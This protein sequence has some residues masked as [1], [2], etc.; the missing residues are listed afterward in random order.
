MHRSSGLFLGGLVLTAAAS[1]AGAQVSS[2]NEASSGAQSAEKSGEPIQDIVVTARRTEENLQRIPVAVTALGANAIR[3]LQIGDVMGLQRAAPSLLVATGS[4][5]GAGFAYVSIRGHFL[6]NPSVENDPSVG[7]YVD[8]V[9]IPRPSQGTVDLV[10]VERAEVLRG[11]QGTLFGRNTPGGALSIVTAQPTEQFEASV[12]GEYGNYDHKNVRAIV[13]GPV[14]AGLSARIVYNFSEHDSYGRN[15][16]TGEGVASRRSHF[17]RGKLRWAPDGSDWDV[18]LSADYNHI[19]GSSQLQTLSGFNPAIYGPAL[20]PFISDRSNFY[21]T[22]F[23]NVSFASQPKPN[24]KIV[25]WGG[26]ATINGQIGDLKVKSITGYR[27]SKPQGSAD[28]DATP[29]AILE[30]NQYYPSRQISQELQVFGDVGDRLKYI[31]GGYYSR[32]TA[33]ALAVARAFGFAFPSLPFA[34]DADVL[35]KSAGLFGQAYYQLTDQLRLTG[36]LRWT[37]DKRSVNLHNVTT[38]GDPSTCNLDSTLP[39]FVAPCSLPQTAKFNYPAWTT[40][41]DFQATPDMLIYAKGSAASQAGGLNTRVGALPSYAPAKT[42][43]VEA[44][45]KTSWFD[46]RLRVNVALFYEWQK[47]V[48]LNKTA[49]VPVI[50]GVTPYLTNAGNARVYGAEFEANAAPW[51]GM[52]LTGTLSLLR[53]HFV[54]G[55][56]NEDQT[57]PSGSTV[58]VDRSGE[59]LPQLPKIQFSIGA[60]QKVP[61]SIGEMSLHL[62]YAYQSSQVFGQATPAA[63]QPQA[64]KDVYALA[65]AANR[66]KGYGALNGRVGL[67]LPNPNLEVYLFGKNLTANKYFVRAYGDLFTAGLGLGIAYQGD[68]R[69]YGIGAQISF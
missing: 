33:R 44:G 26:S 4:P 10:D 1:S 20:T 41:L 43:E 46:K 11:P 35:N 51:Q 59:S 6:A 47:G 42:T 7:I 48:Q 2:A 53:G 21:A 60:T 34:N 36:G 37:W 69:T 24:D 17:V 65:N 38:F 58:V 5:G 29:L 52:L 32:E 64:V 40:S 14:A 57:L 19:R 67:Q 15:P 39:G 12:R 16:L 30:V 8:G 28:L 49:F 68:P 62:D 45:A 50:R 3:T 22:Y 54:G 9:Y 55:T 25:A 31:L 56:F 63:A 66:I 61:L 27:Y 13:N 23:N 18:T